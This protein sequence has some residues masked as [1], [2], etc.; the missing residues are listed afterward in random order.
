MKKMLALL[1][2]LCMALPCMVSAEESTKEMV[3]QM[4]Y[5]VKM[6]DVIREGLYT[7][8][9]QNGVPHGYG[10]FTATNDEGVN[11]HYLGYWVKGEMFGNGGHYWDDGTVWVGTFAKNDFTTGDMFSYPSA[12]VWADYRIKKD[13]CVK[14]KVYRTDGSIIIDGY[15][16]RDTVEFTEGTIYTNRGEVF[17]SGTFGKGF[18]WNLIYVD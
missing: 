18:D 12:H 15:A 3:V 5:I 16:D 8:E 17:F 4:T 13:N 1:L 10:V 9:V 2:V 11:W 7:G 6:P 14:M